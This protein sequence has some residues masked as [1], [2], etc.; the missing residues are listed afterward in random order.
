M[1]FVCH[2]SAHVQSQYVVF[3]FFSFFAGRTLDGAP[4][5]CLRDSVVLCPFGEASEEP[6]AKPAVLG[7]SPCSRPAEGPDEPPARSYNGI[8]TNAL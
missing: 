3:C 4:C 6:A 2:S 8:I 1:A 5:F 7:Q